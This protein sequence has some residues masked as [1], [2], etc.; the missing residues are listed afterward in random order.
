MIYDK[1]SESFLKIKP[2]LNDIRLWMRSN[3]LILNDDKTEVIHFISRYKKNYDR[4]TYFT[5]G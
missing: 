1:P 4:A 5:E 2:C 3:H